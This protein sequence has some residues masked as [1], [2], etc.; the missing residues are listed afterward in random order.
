M[1]NKKKIIKKKKR[2]RYIDSENSNIEIL[3]KNNIIIFL[4]I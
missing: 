3:V 1:S 2:N 4:K